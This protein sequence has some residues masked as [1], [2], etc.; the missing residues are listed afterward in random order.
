[1]AAP[2]GVLG[3][4]RPGKRRVVS[5]GREEQRSDGPT[6]ILCAGRGKWGFNGMKG[7]DFC[8]GAFSLSRDVH[9]AG[10]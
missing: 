2:G 5:F 9:A 4:F 3:G 6:W 8:D 7:C 1:M 10:K